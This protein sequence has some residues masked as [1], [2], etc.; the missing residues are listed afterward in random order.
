M[1]AADAGHTVRVTVTA[2]NVDGQLAASS[3]A[4]DVVSAKGAGAAPNEAPTIA[5][6]SLKRVRT[7]VYARF[8][9]CDDSGSAVAITERD[10]KAHALAFTRRF[11]T[12]P[13]ACT[14]Q[15]RSWVPAARFRTHGRYVVTLRAADKSGALSRLVSRSLVF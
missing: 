7:R 13:L 9:V 12:I 11:A 3:P 6:L 4:T 1:T 2:S 14:T 10:T 8:R 5:F 15:S